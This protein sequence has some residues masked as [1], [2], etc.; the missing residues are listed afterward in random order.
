[1][2]SVIGVAWR[3]RRVRRRVVLD[4]LDKA[5]RKYEGMVPNELAHYTTSLA[6]L[7]V[8]G[9][10]VKTLRLA[11]AVVALGRGGYGREGAAIVRTLLTVVVNMRFLATFA[12]PDE[13]AAAYVFHTQRTNAQLKSHVV[14]DES[15]G[16]GFPTM[17]EGEWAAA[18]SDIDAQME[19]IKGEKIPVMQKFR[20]PGRDGRPRA[21]RDDT[22]TGMSDKEL[23]DYIGERD[24]YRF[25]ALHSNELHANVT[26]LGDVFT[27][28]ASGRVSFSTRDDADAA[29]LVVLSAKYVQSAMRTFDRYQ[30]LDR[31]TEI[32]SISDGFL[33]AIARNR[34]GAGEGGA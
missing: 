28:V 13:A 27:E 4:A 24:G 15:E 2:A 29:R 31:S 20:P 17:S 14:R 10:L 23:F 11:G 22:W 3:R 34:R 18:S 33:A 19:R 1:V 9:M 25:Y 16:G 5:L 12:H 7:L 21:P 32:E 6:G 26:G 8:T 30:Q